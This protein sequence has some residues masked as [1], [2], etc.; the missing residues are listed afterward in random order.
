MNKYSKSGIKKKRLIKFFIVFF[1]ILLIVS[2]TM[3]VFI[4]M[5]KNIIVG[6]VDDRASH[7]SDDVAINSSPIILNN[8]LL[9]GI[10]DKKWVSSERFYLNSK[11]KSNIQIDTYNKDGKGGTY[12]LSSMTKDTSSAAVFCSTT[13]TNHFNEYIALQSNNRN[14]MVNVAS[15]NLNVNEGHI[16]LVKKAL[17]KYMLFNNSVKISKMYDVILESNG[18]GKIIIATNEIGK[19]VGAYSAVIYVS[20]TNKTSI[21]KYNYVRHLKDASDWPVYSFKFAID[22]NGDGIN[23]IILQETSEFNIKYDVIEYRDGKFYEVLSS[24]FKM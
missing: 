12:T 2:I 3:V 7:V 17:G 6:K 8:V 14:C 22:L 9:G 21:V 13:N 16:D 4:F 23:E 18:Y 11:N 5:N 10:Y 24:S 20:P 19:S 15:E 1:S